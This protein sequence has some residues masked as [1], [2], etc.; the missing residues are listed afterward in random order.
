MGIAD[1]F[2]RVP[3]DQ[4]DADRRVCLNGPD[5]EAPESQSDGGRSQKKDGGAGEDVLGCHYLQEEPSEDCSKR[6]TEGLHRTESGC[7][8]GQF[9]RGPGQGMDQGRL[10]GSVGGGYD[11]I[12]C[13][14][15]QEGAN[16]TPAAT[17]PALV[18]T[19]RERTTAICVNSRPPGRRWTNET[20]AML[21]IAAKKSRRPISPTAMA[22][23][24][25]YSSTARAVT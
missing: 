21:P 20:V 7:R 4:A 8:S 25:R 10:G 15:D 22:P 19:R 23:W 3:H 17:R 6:L 1:G 2:D 18:A 12:Q 13:H 11:R 9:R 5:P 24:W 16:G 14:Q